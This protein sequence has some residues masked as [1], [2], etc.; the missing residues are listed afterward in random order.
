[1]T[2]TLFNAP[3]ENALTTR[4]TYYGLTNAPLPISDADVQTIVEEAIKHTPSSF[5]TQTSRAVVVLGDKNKQLWDAIWAAQ[6]E[7][8]PEAAQA[9]FKEKFDNAYSSGHGTVVFFED[10]EGIKKFIDGSAAFAASIPTWSANTNGIAQYIVWSTLATHGIGANLQHYGQ[11]VPP[12][13]AAIQKFLGVPES[14]T[15]VAELPFGVAQGEPGYP[16]VPKAF[17]PIEDRVKV[18]A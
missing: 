16:G 7:L 15:L 5:N 2:N 8:L 9:G 13:Q 18:V 3:I 14:W 4:R 11:N 10:A 6:K 12:V 17:A 1:M